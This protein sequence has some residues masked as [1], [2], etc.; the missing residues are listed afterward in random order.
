MNDDN[1]TIAICLSENNDKHLPSIVNIPSPF[2]PL[3]VPSLSLYLLASLSTK[4]DEYVAWAFSLE[5]VCKSIFSICFPSFVNA[6]MASLP[7]KPKQ[8]YRND[9]STDLSPGHRLSTQWDLRRK[10]FCF[11]QHLRINIG[12]GLKINAKYLHP[13]SKPGLI[14]KW[15]TMYSYMMNKINCCMR[16]TQPVFIVCMTKSILI[17]LPISVEVNIPILPSLNYLFR[18]RKK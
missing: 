17:I 1:I 5:N 4:K 6:W 18:S 9:G 10:L 8:N 14:R 12:K 16:P 11:S 7:E 2:V 3:N 13:Y 15:L